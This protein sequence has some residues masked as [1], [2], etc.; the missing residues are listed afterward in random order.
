MEDYLIPCLSKYLFNIECLGCGAQRAFLL[1]IEGEFIEAFKMYP[2]IYTVL[3]FLGIGLIY[4]F[5]KNKNLLL[6]LKI[7]VGLNLT[8]MIIS[9]IYKH[10]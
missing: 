9:Y 6:L 4:Y 1:L 3:L 10:I 2:A 5:N 8:I 7:L